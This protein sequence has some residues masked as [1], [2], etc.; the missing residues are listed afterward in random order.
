MSWRFLNRYRVRRADIPRDARRLFEQIGEGR[1]KQQFSHNLAPDRHDED[2][3]KIYQNEKLRLQ[4]RQWLVEQEDRDRRGRFLWNAAM[5]GAAVVAAVAAVWLLVAQERRWDAEDRPRLVGSNLRVSTSPAKYEWTFT[6]RGQEDAT[7][8]KIKIATIDLTRAHQTLLTQGLAELPRLKFG[9]I[10]PVTTEAKN[11]L[12]F[13]VVCFDY[14]NDRGTRFDDRPQFYFTPYY[15]K[16][17][18]EASFPLAPVTALQDAK[19]SAGFSC[20]SL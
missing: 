18:Q 19:L 13:L 10:Y 1:L 4:G 5:T 11:D 2:L 14:Y 15:G 17:N 3:L 9:S 12:E 7:R 20:A 6:N 8:V 16:S